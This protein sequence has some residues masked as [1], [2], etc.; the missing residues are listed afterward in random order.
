MPHEQWIRLRTAQQ[1]RGKFSMNNHFSFVGGNEGSWQVV[2]CEAVVGASLETV[3]RINVLNLPA[4]NLAARAVWVLQG[5]TSNVRYAERHEIN[6][7]R[8]KQEGLGRPRAC[9]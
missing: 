8:A 7:L 6:Q 9:Y 4:T 5:F 3:Q 2:S 1:N